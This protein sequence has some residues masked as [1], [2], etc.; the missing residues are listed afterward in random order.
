MPQRGVLTVL[1]GSLAGDCRGSLWLG[2]VPCTDYLS[3]LMDPDTTGLK[4]TKYLEQIYSPGL[5]EEHL[6]C[7]WYKGRASACRGG[8]AGSLLG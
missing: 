4:W 3:L 2:S 7:E 6:L 8:W 5:G 1:H